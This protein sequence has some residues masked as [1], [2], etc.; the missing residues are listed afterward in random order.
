MKL[1]G[2]SELMS[3]LNKYNFSFSK[4]LGQNFLIDQNILNK[5]VSG[6]GINE[7]TNVLEVG[8][9]A[10][11]L[12][13]E[14]C[15]KAKKVTAVEIDKALIPI[16]NDVMSDFDN[17][18]LINSDILELNINELIKNEFDNESFTV[19]ANLP[20]YITTPIIMNFLESELPVNS[21][22]LMIQKEVAARI[23]AEPGTKDYGALSVAVQFYAEP[24]IICSASPHCF[25]PQPKVT[26]TVVNLKLYDKPKYDVKNKEQFFKIVKS[27]FS[28]RRKTLVN[29]LSGSPY[30]DLSKDKIIDVLKQMELN[31]KV[32]GEKLNIEQI[33]ELSN[34][35]YETQE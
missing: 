30:L 21:M 32:R 13:R 35:I 1:S 26:S 3:V 5:I 34:I 9:G 11:T 12:T 29:S 31:E 25:T 27:I 28:Q 4:S 6:S 16:L 24:G 7:N 18:N 20:Y 19:V 14:L 23:L 2:K 10:G 22:T 15:L 33:A 17:F 8:P